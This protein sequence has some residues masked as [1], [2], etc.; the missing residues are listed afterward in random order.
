MPIYEYRCKSCDDVFE[1][2]IRSMSDAAAQKCPKCG[3]KK[4]EQDHERLRRPGHARQGLLA[5]AHGHGGGADAVRASGGHC[6]TCRRCIENRGHLRHPIGEHR[7]APP[8][9]FWEI[10]ESADAVMHLGD[11]VSEEFARQLAVRQDA[12]RSLRQLRPLA[13]RKHISRR[14]GSWISKASRR[15]LCTGFRVT[16]DAAETLWRSTG[17]RACR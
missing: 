13:R 8:A 12:L 9:G 15:S 16:S 10:V 4:T 1:A 5:A 2:L 14:R 17:A 3:G 11:F 7:K 6:S